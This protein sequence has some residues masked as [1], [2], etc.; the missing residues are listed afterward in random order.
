MNDI[1]SGANGACAL[2]KTCA[3]WLLLSTHACDAGVPATVLAV[4]PAKAG[5]LPTPIRER[6][7]AR[8]NGLVMVHRT[9]SCDG[10]RMR[11]ASDGQP[12]PKVIRTSCGAPPSALIG[13]IET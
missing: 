7:I 3:Y 2:S 12:A 5:A 6:T 1:S 10:A 11:A 13:C 9:G 8:V 4:V